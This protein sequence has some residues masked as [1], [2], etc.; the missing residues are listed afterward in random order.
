[1]SS[2]FV[3]AMTTTSSLVPKPSSST[4]SWLSV[5]SRS[6]WLFGPPRALPIASNSSKKMTAAAELAGLGEQ[7]A[8]APRAD[9]DVLL[10]ELRAGRVVER[11]AGLGGDRPGEHRLAGAGRAVEHDAA[12]DPGAQR[13]EALRVAQE[14]DRLGQLELRLVA[15]GDVR[16]G[17]SGRRAVR[18][19][20]R[21]RGVALRGR[22]EDRREPRA[23]VARPR[24]LPTQDAHQED[25]ED[26]EQGQREDHRE[27]R[28]EG[29]G[30][31]GS[32]GR[33]RG[34]DGLPRLGRQEVAMPE[35][36]ECVHRLRAGHVERD[37]DD[38]S[39]T[40]LG[41]QHRVIGAL[42]AGVARRGEGDDLAGIDVPL[43]L[44]QVPRSRVGEGR[45]RPRR[46]TAAWDRRQ[47]EDPDRADDDDQARDAHGPRPAAKGGG[48]AAQR[49]ARIG[50]SRSGFRYGP[51]A[52]GCASTQERPG[53]WLTVDGGHDRSRPTVTPHPF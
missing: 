20:R 10:D 30:R 40:Q 32:L 37:A 26:R 49:T 24:A 21:R 43:Q 51:T 23:D 6:S 46:L 45:P 11:H 17:D 28:A 13:A 14:L 29:L 18:R 5:C 16:E 52:V 3:A 7:V 39:V 42:V 22:R 25:R 4:S 44:Q 8:D 19:R 34:L 53:Q 33:A 12:R 36:R 50:F 31:A 47:P 9:A 27:D 38:L 15:A 2:R 41:Q 1:M 35:V 48:Q